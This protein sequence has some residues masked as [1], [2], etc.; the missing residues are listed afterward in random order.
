[1]PSPQLHD[2]AGAIVTLVTAYMAVVDMLAKSGANEEDT[3]LEDDEAAAQIAD[4][5][6]LPHSP[7]D[8]EK[9][10][11]HDAAHRDGQTETTTTRARAMSWVFFY[12]EKI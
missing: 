1:M 2:F 5:E 11:V 7:E 8:M 12:G 3:V 10:E 9:R 6:S 4:A